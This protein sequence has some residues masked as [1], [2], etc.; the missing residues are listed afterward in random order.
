MRRSK[1]A[2][3]VTGAGSNQP[4]RRR[5]RHRQGGAGWADDPVGAPST[6][7]GT[8]T[9]LSSKRIFAGPFR[10]AVVFQV[11]GTARGGGSGEPW[12]MA[13]GI[14]QASNPPAVAGAVH[15]RSDARHSGQP[16]R[17]AE[18]RWCLYGARPQ[19]CSKS[20]GRVVHLGW[21]QPGSIAA[22]APARRWRLAQAWVGSFQL[23]AATLIGRLWPVHDTRAGRDRGCGPPQRHQPAAGA[24][25]RAS[26]LA[27]R[28]TQQVSGS[29]PGIRCFA[30]GADGHRIRPRS[31]RQLRKRRLPRRDHPRGAARRNSG[32]QRQF[33]HT[34]CRRPDAIPGFTALECSNGAQGRD[35]R[36][37]GYRRGWPPKGEWPLS[38]RA[39]GS[40]RQLRAPA[41]LFLALKA[42]AVANAGRAAPAG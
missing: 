18:L 37:G 26:R 32:D 11:G 36:A 9:G 34:G 41:T 21:H 30:G 12:S 5:A 31:N 40:V 35:K 39:S 14:P 6:P 2:K 10:A 3:A 33:Q 7:S 27:A 13:E 15:S 42:P 16:V 20:G 25:K 4:G 1:R 8:P 38:R 19:L 17:Q 23:G 24:G 29:G 28:P 22:A